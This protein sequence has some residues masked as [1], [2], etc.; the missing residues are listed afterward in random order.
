MTGV[1]LRAGTP[2]AKHFRCHSLSCKAR[3]RAQHGMTAEA[4]LDTPRLQ[5]YNADFRAVWYPKSRAW[6][7][8]RCLETCVDG[9]FSELQAAVIIAKLR[10]M[11][12]EFSTETGKFLG[13]QSSSSGRCAV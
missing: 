6:K 7:P 2:S 5:P 12:F 9:P 4:R 3:A 8:P 1:F 13:L 10:E 11:P